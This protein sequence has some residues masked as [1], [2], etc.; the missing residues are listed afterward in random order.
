MANRKPLVRLGGGI[1]ELPVGDQLPAGSISIDPLT[2][3]ELLDTAT[4]VQDAL[5]TLE[6]AATD[7]TL[8]HTNANQTMTAKLTAHNNTDYTV[9][10]VRNVF[11]STAN[12]TTEGGNGD[13]WIKYTP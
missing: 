5:E 13:I 4:S 6:T 1:E 11:L 2:V 8:M 7:A 9:G 12:P 10:Q 3:G